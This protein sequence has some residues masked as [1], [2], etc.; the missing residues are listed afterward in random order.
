MVIQVS[1]FVPVVPP[2]TTTTT[3]FLKQKLEKTT[4]KMMNKSEKEGCKQ[5]LEMLTYPDLLSLVD[6]TT[7]KQIQ[8][9]RTSEA[10]KAI[11]EY[12]PKAVDLLKR[13]KVKRDLLFK[14]LADQQVVVPVTID[15]SGL[16]RAILKRWGTAIQDCDFMDVDVED[17]TSPN[18][19]ST[20]LAPD[21]RNQPPSYASHTENAKNHSVQ[22]AEGGDIGNQPPSYASHTQ[23]A[24]HQ[25]A[26]GGAKG[27]ETGNKP[28]QF[29][30]HVQQ[31]VNVTNI[32]NQTRTSQSGFQ[33]GPQGVD[34][35]NHDQIQ[36]SG[37]MPDILPTQKIENPST[38][39]VNS[40]IQTLG[41][42][43]A[44]WFY[45]NLNSHCPSMQKSPGDFGPHHFWDD[46]SLVLNSCTPQPNVEKL[47]GPLLVSQ[48]FLA[49]AKDEHVLFN[50]NLTRDGIYVKSNQ[51]GLVMILVCGTVH[52]N[53]DCLGV[54]QQLFGI[55]KDPRF[56]N[57]WKIKM[58]KLDVKT[59]KPTAMPKLEGN[60][61]SQIMSLVA[62]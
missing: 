17:D 13:K 10:L 18:S 53:N 29:N 40:E 47:E 27:S 51:H 41:E 11:I 30:I 23:G 37:S 38:Q 24:R 32:H 52:R 2:I 6:T 25:S 12:T 57:N 62:V 42:K 21:S 46:V 49:F 45:E 39:V 15:K 5:I 54:F 20:L 56:E 61:D 31:Y 1:G 28:A 60:L 9:S 14:Y 7:K 44:E 43:F 33:R 55:V 35:L 34:L 26:Q 8:V 59:S 58:I 50:P 4:R 22:G 3:T 36:A 19:S 48:R 16:I